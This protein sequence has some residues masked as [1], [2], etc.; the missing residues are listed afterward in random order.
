MFEPRSVGSAPREGVSVLNSD[1][2]DQLSSEWSD[3]GHLQL[4]ATWIFFQLCIVE[5][6]L[7]GRRSAKPPPE[8]VTDMFYW[9][10]S[11][12][13][14]V[15]GRMATTLLLALAFT[16]AG[17]RAVPDVMHGFGPVAA[18]P[19]WLIVVELVVLM[20]LATYW[21]HR[22]FHH[23][24]WLWRFHAIHHSA[25]EVRWSTTGR[26]HPVNEVATYA[27]VMAPFVLVGF[28]VALMVPILPFVAFYAMFAHAQ[29]HL[30]LGPLG[31]VLVG[32]VFHR[33]HHTHP[34]EGGD[35]NF[36]NVFALWD[37]LFGT[38][39]MPEGRRPERYG[40]VGEEVPKS[41]LGQLAYPF[42]RRPGAGVPAPAPEAL[43]VADSERPPAPL[44]G[45]AV[46][47]A[48]GAA[49]AGAVRPQ[50]P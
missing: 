34:D 39:Y 5:G 8:L 21:T 14:R 12:T 4:C 44:P 38:R 36:G 42:R 31:K 24:P 30:D 13:V 49:G 28:P 32:P 10:L 43:T 11:P 47:H 9:L 18:Q 45:Q 33:W 17:V 29:F 41:F 26:V 27:V 7:T 23:F 6:L 15:F 20:D 35:R 16:A 1:L 22:A 40:V 50:V 2:I 37:G 19:S 46:S 48:R 3:F 25:E